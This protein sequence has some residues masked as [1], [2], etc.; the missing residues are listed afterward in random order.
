MD[1]REAQAWIVPFIEGKLNDEQNEK[2]IEH[3]EN[4]SE[5]YDELE[6][7]YIVIV[8]TKQLDEDTHMIMD[9]GANLKTYISHVK[10]HISRKHSR[11]ARLRFGGFSCALLCILAVAF[12]WYSFY[13]HPDRVARRYYGIASILE[14]DVEPAYGKMSAIEDVNEVYF[15]STHLDMPLRRIRIK[16]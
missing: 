8:G 3:I 4:C 10:E 2:F 1:C 14:L 15:E 13:T 5:C 6:V 16:D 9:F 7:Y 12:L 11:K